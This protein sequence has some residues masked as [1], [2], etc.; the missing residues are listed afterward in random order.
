MQS[1][2]DIVLFSTADWHTPYWTN[3]QHTAMHLAKAGYRVLYVETVGLRQLK[4]GSGMDLGRLWRRF[5]LG[6]KGPRQISESIWV[7][8]P[9]VVPLKHHWSFFRRLN[10]NLLAL[11]LRGFFKKE[12]FIRPIIWT[13]HPFILGA[14]NGFNHAEL[15]YHCVDDLSA[16]PG[17]DFNAFK[18]EEEQLLRRAD[19][20]F[21]TSTTLQE[22]CQKI[23]DNVHFLPN[24]ADYDHFATARKVAE[25]PAELAAI[26][27]PRIGYIGVLSDFKVDFDLIFSIAE[28]RPDWHWVMIG[29][30]REGQSSTKVK[31]LSELEN[32][33][34]LGH[35]PYEQ[36]PHY[37][38][39][40]NV[41]TLPTL[42]NSYTASM[43]PMKY[44]EYLAAGVPVV[45]TPLTFTQTYE[46][47][48]IV[49][50]DSSSFSDALALQINK[51]RISE[52]S[53][54]DYVGDNTWQSR[55]KVMLVILT[56]VKSKA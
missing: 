21:T 34:F 17:V 32:V 4:L 20:V 55:L 48:L 43:F 47:G 18:A 26:P 42:I 9:L 23:S 13:Y 40:M 30:E 35:R 8:S 19:V 37:L 33:H 53:S 7:L 38:A 11:Y 5:W 50:E 41:A 25:L 44:F 6:L 14:I 27:E 29:E 28:N 49:A 51:G 2:F 31:Q 3:K 46:S 12:C 56:S 52:Q 10:Q 16:M 15:V 22:E 39:G 36:L 45:S 24:V 54:K 1:N